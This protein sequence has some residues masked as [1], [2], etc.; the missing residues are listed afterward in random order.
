MR[1]PSI[2]SVSS[3]VVAVPLQA[4]RG[5]TNERRLKLP[6]RSAVARDPN[7]KSKL[8]GADGDTAEQREAA[9]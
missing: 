7:P 2:S 4:E 3:T 5:D 9:E 6:K 1:P 8:E